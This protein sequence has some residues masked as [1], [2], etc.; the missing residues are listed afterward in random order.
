MTCQTLI[1]QEP[2]LSQ[3]GRATLRV[4]ENLA[5]TQDRPRSYEIIPIASRG[6]NRRVTVRQ[7]LM[8]LLKSFITHWRVK[9]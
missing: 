3:R 2:Q 1:L 9:W 7:M 5:V 8:N 6:K 4:V